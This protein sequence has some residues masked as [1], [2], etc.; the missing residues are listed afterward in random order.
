VFD[1]AH[2]ATAAAFPRDVVLLAADDIYNLPSLLEAERVTTL[3]KLIT[4]L[5]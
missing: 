4:E 3:V 1:F 2:S 5:E